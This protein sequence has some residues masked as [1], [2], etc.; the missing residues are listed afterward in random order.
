ML[1]KDGRIGPHSWGPW[2]TVEDCVGL[3]PFPTYQAAKAVAERALFEI[4]AEHQKD[5]V[6]IIS[7]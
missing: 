5:G 6:D 7:S 2:K 4:A 3:E 1:D